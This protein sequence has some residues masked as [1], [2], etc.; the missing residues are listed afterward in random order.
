MLS[1]VNGNLKLIRHKQKMTFSPNTVPYSVLIDFSIPSLEAQ[2]PQCFG[3]VDFFSL[4]SHDLFSEIQ[5]SSPNPNFNFTFNTKPLPSPALIP[6]SKFQPD[7]SWIPAVERGKWLVFFFSF[8][9]FHFSKCQGRQLVE[10][11]GEK[12]YLLS[13]WEFQF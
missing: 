2:L 13:W 12:D 3:Y 6:L 8:V 4:K 11:K 1:T 9:L 7:L 5:K 10:R